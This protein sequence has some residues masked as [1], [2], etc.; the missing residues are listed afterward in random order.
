MEQECNPEPSP[1][2]C[3]LLPTFP[4][5]ARTV[6]IT[7]TPTVMF[8]HHQSPL[9]ACIHCLAS[10]LTAQ[11]ELKQKGRKRAQSSIAHC[12]LA[13]CHR[14]WPHSFHSLL[15]LRSFKPLT[16]PTFLQQVT[17]LPT[18]LDLLCPSCEHQT[19]SAA[20]TAFPYK[21]S[22]IS[23]ESTRIPESDCSLMALADS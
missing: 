11:A 2:R 16:S 1:T 22:K 19:S 5:C 8:W 3:S 20:K 21:T 15:V 12:P 10:G 7:C 6:A 17:S 23:R 9:P 18:I 13:L 4:A 14:A